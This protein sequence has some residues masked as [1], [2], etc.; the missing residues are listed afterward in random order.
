MQTKDL[1]AAETVLKKYADVRSLD[2]WKRDVYVHA[3]SDTFQTT[4][5]LADGIHTIVEGEQLIDLYLE[6]RSGCPLVVMFNG[7]QDR[8]KTVNLPAFSG[9]QAVP[10][11]MASRLFINDPTLYL[12]KEISI[13]WYAGSKRLLLQKIL[14]NIIR[15]VANVGAAP[16][17]IFGGGSNGAF[18]SLYYSSLFANSLAVASNPQTHPLNYYKS[19]AM[20]Y[21]SVAFDLDGLE[22]ARNKLPG[23]IDC[24][25]SKIYSSGVEN[26][27][28]YIQNINDAF[29]LEQHCRPF[30]EAQGC[31]VP[32][33]VMIK[34]LSERLLLH[35]ADWGGGHVG[36]KPDYW[37]RLLV[38]L[39]DADANWK[40]LFS[41]QGR[42]AEI[43][44]LSVEQTLA[45]RSGSSIEK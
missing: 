22:E 5:R 20:R 42:V 38:N 11:D 28:I 9:L 25:L 24:D 45:S 29:H 33:Q 1:F 37:R 39:I 15:H 14:P 40:D 4:D 12:S 19:H 32:N 2:R 10:G 44:M 8:S 43:I 21:A 13:G 31:G 26:C 18:A 41:K 23:F 35:V 6:I 3:S 27:A 34:Q 30:V 7:A 17:M 16:R 36:P